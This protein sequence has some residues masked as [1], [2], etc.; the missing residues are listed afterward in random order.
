MSDKT[1]NEVLEFYSNLEGVDRMITEPTPF[2]DVEDSFESVEQIGRIVFDSEDIDKRRRI[3]IGDILTRAYQFF[4]KCPNL[5]PHM[6]L[7]I[8]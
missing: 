3:N 8:R 6:I 7:A 2:N 1:I 4:R 5:E